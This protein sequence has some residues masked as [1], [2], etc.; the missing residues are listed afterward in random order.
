MFGLSSNLNL[1]LNDLALELSMAVTTIVSFS[2]YAIYLVSVDHKKLFQF[3][4]I[5][6]GIRFIVLYFQALGGLATTGFGLILSGVIMIAM[7]IGWNKNRTAIAAWAE[8]I[9]K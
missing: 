7:A 1:F 3:F 5:L 2:C 8:R 4:V 9:S 6:V